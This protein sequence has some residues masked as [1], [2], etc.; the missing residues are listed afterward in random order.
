MLDKLLA[1]L[2]AGGTHR[3]NDLAD[4]LDTTP[5]LVDMM[6]E[7]L[8]RMGYLKPVSGGCGDGC[9]SCPMSAMCTVG[10]GER[11]W[12]LTDGLSS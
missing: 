1:L 3:V 4:I 6:L 5:D 9:S 11:I 7:D 12:T 8:A 10:S 2:R